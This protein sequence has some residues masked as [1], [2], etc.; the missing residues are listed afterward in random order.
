M[1]GIYYP[2]PGTD[3]GAS[4][5]PPPDPL[6]PPYGRLNATYVFPALQKMG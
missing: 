4:I 6:P 5:L 1:I 2:R 3:T